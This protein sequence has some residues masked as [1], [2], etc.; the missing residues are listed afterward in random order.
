MAKMGEK[1]T[2]KKEEN[3]ELN[4]VSPILKEK[5]GKP[6]KPWCKENPTPKWWGQQR[7]TG[8]GGEEPGRTGNLQSQE[9]Q[10]RKARANRS[11]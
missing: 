7:G 5:E 2:E 4:C 10:R 3:P 6:D 9:N 11:G 1:E 8:G